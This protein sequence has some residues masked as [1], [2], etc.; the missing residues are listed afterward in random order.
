M[1]EDLSRRWENL[2]LTEAED[3]E[4]EIRKET[5]EGMVRWGT[6][7]LVWKL[8]LDCYV[9][10]EVIKSSL[11]RGWKS[12]GRIPFK[13]VGE[14]LFLIEFEHD[15][16]K[17]RALKWRP[18][19]IEGSLFSVAELAYMNS[20][21]GTMIGSFIG[22]VEEVET[23]ED[24]VGW[25]QFLRV[26][27]RVDLTKPLMRG[28]RL[29]VQG[30]SMW[31]DFQYEQL[32]RICFSCGVVK[33]G[34]TGCMK[35]LHKG[36]AEYGPWLRALLPGQRFGGGLVWRRGRT[37]VDHSYHGIGSNSSKTEEKNLRSSSMVADMESGETPNS[38]VPVRVN[39]AEGQTIFPFGRR[40]Q[41]S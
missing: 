12:T 14:N 15:W 17:A 21:I 40:L 24:G 16:E 19:V 8:I 7:C 3:D 39:R 18:W 2:S 30:V 6:S 26:K 25:G 32:P 10:K 13:V 29:K 23:D 38:E 36:G 41:S 11:M 9:S 31:V 37:S 20:D 1:E 5:M 28:R 22:Q 27:I 34:A 4:M 35:N 33:H